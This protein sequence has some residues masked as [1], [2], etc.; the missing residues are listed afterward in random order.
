[1]T[2]TGMV[3][4]DRIE[5][6]SEVEIKNIKRIVHENIDC[7]MWVYMD[8]C[9]KVFD[10]GLP[11]DLCAQFLNEHIEAP[12]EYIIN[13]I[14]IDFKKANIPQVNKIHGSYVITNDNRFSL[15]CAKFGLKTILPII[16]DSQFPK[17]LECEN[18]K[19]I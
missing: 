17:L 14:N 10:A 5:K 18:N 12:C 3:I 15:Y 11:V 6:F 19:K 13:Q 7:P 1:M 9:E 16:N 2:V 8:P 4:I